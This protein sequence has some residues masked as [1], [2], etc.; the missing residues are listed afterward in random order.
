MKLSVPEARFRKGIPKQTKVLV[1][2]PYLSY[3]D[4]S[5]PK[6]ARSVKGCEGAGGEKVSKNKVHVYRITMKCKQNYRK[7]HKLALGVIEAD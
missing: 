2:E 4:C 1:N 6:A 3:A 7:I 5:R